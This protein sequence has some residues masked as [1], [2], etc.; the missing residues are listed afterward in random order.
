[1]KYLAF[2][3]RLK[4]VRRFQKTLFSNE[5]L[6]FLQVRPLL[7]QVRHTVKHSVTL[8]ADSDLRRLNFVCLCLGNY[9]IRLMIA[10]PPGTPTQV[11]ETKGP[12]EAKEDG[13]GK[14]NC[15]LCDEFIK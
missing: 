14:L 2:L 7:L 1:M 8:A 13:A 15:S 12:K 11:N 3:N 6:C 5:D 4:I 10:P 9:V